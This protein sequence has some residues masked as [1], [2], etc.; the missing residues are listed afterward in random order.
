MDAPVL[1]HNNHPGNRT[2]SAT[3][4]NTSNRHQLAHH[5]CNLRILRRT[6]SEQKMKSR[7]YP[8]YLGFELGERIALAITHAMRDDMTPLKGVISDLRHVE[9]WDDVKIGE[10]FMEVGRLVFNEEE[11]KKIGAEE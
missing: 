7:A 4:R 6:K 9:G 11:S 10:T 2:A 3:T 5:S 8:D 1:G